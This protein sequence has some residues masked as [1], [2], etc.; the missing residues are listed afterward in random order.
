MKIN[1]LVTLSAIAVSL[2]V[3]AQNDLTFNQNIYTENS[4]KVNGQTVEFRAYEGIPYVKNP[5]DSKFQTLNIYVPE[6]YF[7]NHTISGYT[8]QTAPI[9]LPNGVGGYMPSRPLTPKIDEHSHSANALLLALQHGYVVASP[10]ARGRT[11]Q[12]SKGVYTGKAPAAIVDLKA[13][14][15]YLHFNDKSIPGDANK[16]ISNGTSAGGAL[17]ALLGASG[18]QD[19]YDTYLEQLGAAPA[20]DKIYAVSAFCP[21]TDLDHADAAYEWQFNGYNDYKKMDISMLDYHIQR[22]ET[23]GT[24]T[25]DQQ[26]VSDAL[27][28]QFP[29]YLNGLKLHDSNGNPLTLDKN[30]N[31]SFKK[32]VI[33]LIQDSAQSALDNNRDLSQFKWLT[34]TDGKVTNIDFDKYRTYA[35]RAKLPPAFDALDLSAGENEL[36]GNASTNAMHFTAYSSKNSSTDNS[37]TAAANVVYMMNPLSFIQPDQQGIAPHWRI[38]VGTNDRDT[39]LAISAILAT[40]LENSDYDVN[41]HLTWDRPHSGDYNLDALFSWID[42]ISQN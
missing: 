26:I 20:S 23:K 2:S 32:Y 1:T 12:N 42:S 37:A 41:Y 36:F 39:S 35:I 34:I 10:G 17:S 7:K 4:A 11:S 21:I 40:R 3:S 9:F 33:S 18:D 31:G 19:I 13:A 30:G 8:I 22:K 28:S 25:K 29:G 5:V 38:R 15:R 6:G 14:V 16:I 24:L 27:A